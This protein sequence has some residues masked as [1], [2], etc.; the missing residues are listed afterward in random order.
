[1]QPKCA[2]VLQERKKN[3][4]HKNDPRCRFFNKTI[5]LKV[6]LLKF[7]SINPATSVAYPN[8]TFLYTRIVLGPYKRHPAAISH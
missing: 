1:M 7:T 2:S 4:S 5:Y 8:T 6:N 3:I